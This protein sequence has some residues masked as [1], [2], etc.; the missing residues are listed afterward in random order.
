MYAMVSPL[1]GFGKFVAVL[2]A[3]SVI[4]NTACSLYSL[5]I[6]LQVLLPTLVRVPRYVF[7]VLITAIVIPISVVA[8][9]HFYASLGNFLGIIGYWTAVYIG[10][11]L[12]EHFY[13]RKGSYDSYD[14]S[15]W[16]V[17]GKLPVGTAALASS[18][19]CFALII[20]SMDA[21]WYI[22]PIAMHTGDIG[23]EVGACLSS[24][25]YIPLRTLEIRFLGR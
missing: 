22:G 4:G 3:F 1:G 13:F 7:S 5:S 17:R 21:V 20:P 19:L 10:V 12:T 23:I 6:S 14:P 8:A 2:L 16:N 9:N 11:A 15:I 25:L 24:L 18:V